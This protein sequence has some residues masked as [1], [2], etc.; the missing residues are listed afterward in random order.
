LRSP[1]EP[2]L[3][4]RLYAKTDLLQAFFQGRAARTCSDS[5]LAKHSSTD[6]GNGIKVQPRQFKRC[7]LRAAHGHRFHAERLQQAA[8]AR[9]GVSPS[10]FEN[11]HF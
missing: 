3:L 1:V 5:M 6:G 9:F 11:P 10:L 2:S 7:A 4:L 8:N